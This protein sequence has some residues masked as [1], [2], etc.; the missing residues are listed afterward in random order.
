M[1][2]VKQAFVEVGWGGRSLIALYL[3]LFSGLVV[4]LQ[5]DP[6]HPFYASSALELLAPF[7]VFWRSLHFYA[8]QIFFLTL[9]L[10]FLAVVLAKTHLRLPVR[11]WLS[12]VASMVAALLLLFTGYILRGDATGAMAGAIAENIIKSIPLVGEGLNNLLFAVSREGL[13]RVYAQH[14]AGLGLLWLVLA[15]DHLRR[16]RV[17]WNKYGFFGLALV[18]VAMVWAAPMDPERLGMF[19]VNGPWFFIG[20]QEL[21]RYLEPFLAGVLWPL[22]LVGAILLLRA[23]DLGSRRATIFILFWLAL[24]LGLTIIGWRRG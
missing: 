7:G 13:K 24:Y 9:L 17:G 15:W 14:L 5:Y 12:L 23:D 19:H 3:S 10:H 20:L 2:R 18:G 1:L 21:L 4:A 8:S 22:G 6:G 11:H 16:Y